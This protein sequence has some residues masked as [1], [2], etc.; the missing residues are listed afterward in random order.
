[1]ELCDRPSLGHRPQANQPD[2]FP[3]GQLAPWYLQHRDQGWAASM[4]SDL[5]SSCGRLK[6]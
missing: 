2:P 5:P 1:M 6:R 3:V 4:A